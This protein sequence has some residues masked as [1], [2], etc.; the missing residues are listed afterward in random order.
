MTAARTSVIR[1]KAGFHDKLRFP[2]LGT[3]LVLVIAVGIFG[4]V[5]P[6]FLSARNVLSILRQS[7]P[8]AMAAYGMALVIFTGMIDLSTGA[9]V[10]VASMVGVFVGQQLGSP[11]FGWL[12]GV[13][14][15]ILF[16]LVNG[17]MVSYLR[18]PAF[19]ATF[20]T[21]TFGQGIAL[22]IGGGQPFEFP[23]AG[24]NKLGQGALGPLPLP[25]VIALVSLFL[26]H[27]FVTRTTLGRQIMMIGGNRR[28]AALSGVAVPLVQVAAY[29]IA[30]LLA[31]VAGVIL[32]SRVNS[33]Q[34]LLHPT[35]QFEAIAA[36]AVGGVSLRGGKGTMFQVFVGALFLTVIGNGLNLINISTY[37]QLVAL[38]AV[39]V[40]AL[41]LGHGES[42][43]KW[44]PVVRRPFARG[45]K[46]QTE[47]SGGV[48]NGAG[49]QR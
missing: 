9:T 44:W 38:G 21:L 48:A 25:F 35:L 27:L 3:L 42:G 45:G 49:A 4:L 26:I 18:I 7:A 30:G 13:M 8:L 33:G 16:G 11:W 5:Q 34:P 24:Y 17:F 43:S 47:A 15:G 2:G 36:A 12:A 23:P 22:A 28:T 41:I 39:T 32:S 37:W 6:R 40:L 31:G 46:A 19:I 29:V 20:G 1:G 10:A 14:V